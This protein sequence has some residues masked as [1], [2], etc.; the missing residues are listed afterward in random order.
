[1]FPSLGFENTFAI[2]IRRSDAQRLGIRSIGEAVSAARRWRAAFGYEFLNRSDGYPGLAQRYGLRFAAPPTA[3][4]LGLTYR[5]LADGRVD[6]IASDSTNGLIPA[7]KLQALE[8]DRRYFPPY[9][10]VPV[11]NA[12]SC[13]ATPSWWPWW[14]AWRV[15][16]RPPPCS[17]SM[18]RW[19]CSGA[20][21]RRWCTA[22]GRSKARW[23][24]LMPDG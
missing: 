22:G 5:A 11:F 24:K 18:P 1:M 17:A 4:D 23:V 6:L 8:D 12:A 16:S 13:G 2:L 19:I 7:L 3:M 21:P 10:A 14:R 20:A 15:G 9:D